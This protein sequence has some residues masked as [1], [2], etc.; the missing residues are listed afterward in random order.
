MVKTW[1]GFLRDHSPDW[2]LPSTGDWN[3]WFY[4]NYHPHCVNLDLMWFHGA[5]RFPRV[6]TKLDRNPEILQREFDN[7]RQVYSRAPEWVP[8]PLSFGRLGDFWALWMEGLPGAPLQIPRGH[9][10]PL[11]G[12]IAEMIASI[13]AAVRSEASPFARLGFVAW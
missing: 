10:S 7:L 3:F 9:V 6:A 1:S 2:G 5:D 13:H 4:N 11:L 8:R 12:R